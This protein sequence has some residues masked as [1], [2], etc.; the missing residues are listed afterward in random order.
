MDFPVIA[1]LLFAALCMG[2]VIG[3]RLTLKQSVLAAED[4]VLPAFAYLQPFK[5]IPGAW[6]EDGAVMFILQGHGFKVVNDADTGF[7]CWYW[8]ENP[9]TGRTRWIRALPDAFMLMLDRSVPAAQAY[10]EEMEKQPVVAVAPVQ[11]RSSN[12][13]GNNHEQPTLT[14]AECADAHKARRKFSNSEKDKHI[15]PKRWEFVEDGNRWVIE[16]K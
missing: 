2:I 8:D 14:N 5:L 12:G 10:Y 9:I 11:Q 1:I 15:L 4:S 6:E 7:K 16:R 13:S 3:R